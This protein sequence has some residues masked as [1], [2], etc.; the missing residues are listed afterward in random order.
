[1]WLRAVLTATAIVAVAVPALVVTHP[2]AMPKPAHTRVVL[3]RR[4]VPPAELPPVEPVEFVDLSPE[5]A[6]AF[7]AGVPFSTLPNPAARPFR[8]VGSEDDRA[9]ATDCMAAGVLYE[10]GDDTEGERAV[11]QVVLNRLRHPAFPKT[12]CGVIFEGQ[13]RSTGCQFSFSCDHALTRWSPT[14]DAWRRARDVAEQALAGAVYK[15]VGYATHYHTDW[16]VPYWQASLDKVVAVHSHLFFRWTGWWGTPPAFN[17]Q[18]SS[19]EPV[20]AQ[21]APLSDAH[22]T[23]MALAE[24]D[25]A[26]IEASEALGMVGEDTLAAVAAVAADGTADPDSFLVTL[27]RGIAVEQYPALA[28]RACGER[29]I[30][31]YAAWSDAAKTPTSFPLAPEQVATMAFSYLRDR[32]TGVEKAL[33][34]CAQTK[35]PDRRQCMKQQVLLTASPAPAAT[36]SAAAAKQPDELVGVRRKA[37]VAPPTTPTPPAK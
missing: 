30:C 10:A 24:A 6:K 32:D 31:K 3:Q 21:L 20:I 4:V 18:V 23:G 29:R 35:R 28:M 37:D 11:A 34:N 12:V 33:W 26:L 25:A 14:A 8:F 9:R 1:M 16:V 2:P 7:N 5:D 13:E 22:K 27:P 36:P 17:R 19:A 15:R